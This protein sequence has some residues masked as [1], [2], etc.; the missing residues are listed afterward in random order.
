MC[1]VR[2][3]YVDMCCM[4]PLVLLSVR[5]CVCVFAFVALAGKKERK[6]EDVDDL[7]CC[8]LLLLLRETETVVGMV[9]I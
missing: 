8:P 1:C 9:F 3:R 2:V 6:D 7:I 4:Y 5:V